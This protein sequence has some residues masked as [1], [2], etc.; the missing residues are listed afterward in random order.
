V[1]RLA[2]ALLLVQ[3]EEEGNRL[4]MQLNVLLVE[5]RLCGR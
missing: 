2:D 1:Y 3:N 5:M 4:L